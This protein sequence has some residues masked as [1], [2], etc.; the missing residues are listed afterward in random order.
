MIVNADFIEGLKA[1]TYK[2]YVEKYEEE[3][4]IFSRIA[5]QDTTTLAYVKETVASGG[6][7]L[8]RKP[9]GGDYN[10]ISVTEAWTPLIRVV[11]FG[12]ILPIEGA[13]LEDIEKKVGNILKKWVQEW[14]TSARQTKEYLVADLLSYGGYA[15]G[16]HATFDNTDPGGAWSDSSGDYIYDGKPYFNLSTND[17]T[18]KNLDTYHNLESG[19]TLNG[20]GIED[21]YELISETNAFKD[22]GEK[23]VIMPNILV[24]GTPTQEFQARRIL[25]SAQRAGTDHND[26]NVI[27]NLLDVVRNP[28]LSAAFKT[29][30]AWVM[31]KKGFGVKIYSRIEPEFDFWEDKDSN[32]FK[33][34]IRLRC[35]AGVTNWR[36]WAANDI[37]TS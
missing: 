8:D 31:G 27:Q 37:P 5:E 11:E 25:E 26:K 7:R 23:M 22:N 34:R 19:L 10:Q 35:G 13:T 17:R 12:N 14:G 33:T 2:W 1:D 36:G 21:L 20:A 3:P 32:T 16:H 15:A 18:A 30:G 28:F 6:G 24:V 4:E 29:A 9:Y